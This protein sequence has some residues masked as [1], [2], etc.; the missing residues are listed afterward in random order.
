MGCEPALISAV[1]MLTP[2]RITAV[3]LIAGLQLATNSVDLSSFCNIRQSRSL[4]GPF[5][6]AAA[7][8][9]RIG[10]TL[11][12]G[13]EGNEDFSTALGIDALPT[14]TQP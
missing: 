12:F 3:S 7:T 13:G 11:D 9:A 14:A 5:H 2:W 6:G 10:G 1:T 4:V 8:T